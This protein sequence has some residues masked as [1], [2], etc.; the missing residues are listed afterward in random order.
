MWQISLGPCHMPGSVLRVRTDRHSSL[1][2]RRVK[3]A[4]T[5]WCDECSRRGA[6]MLGRWLALL[7]LPKTGRICSRSLPRGG[8]VQTITW[9]SGSYPGKEKIQIEWIACAKRPEL[10]ETKCLLGLVI[11]FMGTHKMSESEIYVRI[12]ESSQ[13]LSMTIGQLLNLLV[14][15]LFHL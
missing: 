3:Q 7:T 4:I 11:H 12:L 15:A 5:T 14:P 6:G 13:I 2:R 8:I 10:N 1:R 9:R